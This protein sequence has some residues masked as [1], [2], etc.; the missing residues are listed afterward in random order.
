VRLS[1]L[2]HPTLGGSADAGSATIWVLSVSALVAAA[3]LLTVTLGSLAVTRHRTATAAD[4]G[5]IAAAG[6]LGEGVP[7]ACAR[8]G[9]VVAAA[10]AR[11]AR[12]APDGTGAVVVTAQSRPADTVAGL[13]QRVIAALPPIR[14]SARA[15]P[16]SAG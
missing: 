10:G 1:R 16:P 11:L 12:C 3:G 2:V 6:A 7:I 14:A 15:G 8:A 4:L 13:L 9:R 5:A